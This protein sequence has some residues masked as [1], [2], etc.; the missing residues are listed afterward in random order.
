M[1]GIIVSSGSINKKGLLSP[2][3]FKL[4]LFAALYKGGDALKTIINSY[5]SKVKS[6][7]M[8]TQSGLD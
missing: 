1:L 2:I 4:A 6:N 5:F 8:N 3:Q 7:F